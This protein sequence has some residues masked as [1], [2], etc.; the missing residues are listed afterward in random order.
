M[1]E[2][3]ILAI[4]GFKIIPW[5]WSQIKRTD[6]SFAVGLENCI[7][8]LSYISECRYSI[9][10]ET[11]DNNNY[12]FTGR[13]GNGILMH[14]IS[15]FLGVSR[16]NFCHLHFFSYFYIF[17]IKP[18]TCSLVAAIFVVLKKQCFLTYSVQEWTFLG[19]V[20]KVKCVPVTYLSSL[21]S[22]LRRFKLY[23]NIETMFVHLVNNVRLPAQSVI[24][25]TASPVCVIIIMYLIYRY[26]FA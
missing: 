10:S 26:K 3:I 14:S 15:A 12:F 9:C 7:Y 4:Y 13:V 1:A 6:L 24:D 2:S 19:T 16:V 5:F 21:I 23:S 8:P 22:E 20:D 25:E 17:E 11:C 18:K